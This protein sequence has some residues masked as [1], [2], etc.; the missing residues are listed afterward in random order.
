[1]SFL[2]CVLCISLGSS[3]AINGILYWLLKSSKEVQNSALETVADISNYVGT[4]IKDSQ[5]KIS[6][7]GGSA[8]ESLNLIKANLT[9]EALKQIAV[10]TSG[11]NK[12]LKATQKALTNLWLDGKA[13][14]AKFF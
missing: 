7:V 3:L 1:M 11:K 14:V 8:T 6:E 12:V 5:D 13:K 4:V 2:V 9:S 10:T